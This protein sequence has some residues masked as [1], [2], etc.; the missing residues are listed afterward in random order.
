MLKE[1]I[2]AEIHFP[3]YLK[4]YSSSNCIGGGSPFGISQ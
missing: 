3:M 1:S 2:G 4:P